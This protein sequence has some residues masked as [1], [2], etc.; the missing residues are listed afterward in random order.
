MELGHVPA[1][2]ETMTLDGW[3]FTVLDADKK[4]VKRLRMT[5]AEEKEEEPAA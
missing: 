4:H 2:G 3:I 5:R 1:V